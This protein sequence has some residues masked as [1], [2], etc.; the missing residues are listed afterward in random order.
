MSVVIAPLVQG[1]DGVFSASPEDILRLK[2]EYE[3]RNRAL[4][5][6]K[7]HRVSRRFLPVSD[8]PDSETPVINL[9]FR[10]PS[11]LFFI[12]ASGAKWPVERTSIVNSAWLKC[13]NCDA[14]VEDFNNSIEIYSITPEGE[15]YF[16]V[17][18][19]GRPMPVLIK[20]VSSNSH[21]D[22]H[23]ITDIGIDELRSRDNIVYG[24]TPLFEG[25]APDQDLSNA[26]ANIS[27]K[28]SVEV[29]TD[30]EQ[31]KVWLQGD[32]LIV[33]TKM[34]IPASKRRQTNSSGYIAYRL[35][36]PAVSRILAYSPEG[37]ATSVRVFLDD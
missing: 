34:R 14:A 32:S 2:K 25:A 10:N 33:R 24:T 9:L 23:A 8:A 35:G 20:A 7:K 28:D 18:L 29:R 27:P 5:T 21:S 6:V 36:A 12:D 3:N 13:A 1:K 22:Y 11:V 17:Y 19:E 37:V 26:L 31:F 4:N 15:A 16:T 30:N